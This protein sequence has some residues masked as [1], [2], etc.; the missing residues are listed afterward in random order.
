MRDITPGSDVY[1]GRGITSQVE[2]AKELMAISYFTRTHYSDT[3]NSH[4]EA[5]MIDVSA[6]AD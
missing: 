5:Q 4:H 1:K 3:F 2:E 6:V